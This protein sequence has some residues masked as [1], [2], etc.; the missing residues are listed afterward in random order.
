[1]QRPFRLIVAGGRDFQDRA[2]L[3]AAI[4]RA[5]SDYAPA[6]LL[7]QLSEASPYG[8]LQIIS[9]GARGADL[10]GEQW[11]AERD[12]PVQRFPARWDDLKAEG[13]VVRTKNGR[14]YNANA[15]FARNLEMARNA[16]AVLVMPGGNGTDH[17]VRVALEQG[18]PV[19]D[20]RSGNPDAVALLT[21]RNE[22]P[23]IRRVPMHYGMPHE[24]LRADLRALYPKGSTTLGLIQDGHRRGTTRNRF[25]APGEVIQFGD[26]PTPYRVVAVELPDLASPEGRQR[27][28]QLEG[29]DLAYIDRT[30][31]LKAQVYSPRVVQ[32]VFEP[33]GKA[34]AGESAGPRIRNGMIEELGPNDVFV[35]GSNL[36]GRHGKGA[37]LTAKQRFGAVYG[38]GE[39]I[40]GRSYALPTK[41][42][43]LRPLPLEDVAAGLL[44]LGSQARGLPDRT[45]YLTRVGQGLA[46]MREDDIRQAVLAAKLP[47]NV[48]PWWDWE[49]ASGKPQPEP[50][51]KQKVAA[52][53]S[54][55]SP[56]SDSASSL[57]TPETQTFLI[58]SRATTPLGR[59]LSPLN[60][61]LA[62]GRTTQNPAT[63]LERILQSRQEAEAKQALPPTSS[64]SGRSGWRMAGDALPYLAAAGGGVLLLKAAYDALQDDAQEQQLELPLAPA[65]RR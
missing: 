48:K 7:Q 62:D 11:A 28:E 5:I 1:M 19:W 30:P 14:T 21:G 39:G 18:L 17:M 9:G 42:A 65:S 53:K 55:A 36:A 64:G 44:Q 27:W 45:F 32:T 31:Q 16:D 34:T 58:D 33:A 8:P 50:A 49:S 54:P 59:A 41:D 20:A 24:A 13:A 57:S 43:D 3:D 23:A 15:G 60:A 22:E 52:G 51:G 2:V 61:R 12:V 26:D 4:E 38:M 10:L 35:F 56:L 47:S 6:E 46:G 25:A 29:W 37:A 40:Q 63:A